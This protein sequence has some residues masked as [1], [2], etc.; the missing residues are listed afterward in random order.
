[1]ANTDKFLDL[2][3]GLPQLWNNAKNK[4]VSKEA[5]KGLVSID[6][7]LDATSK[8]SD[9]TVPSTKLMSDQLD[10]KANSADVA[11]TYVA[12]SSISQD[13]A[14]DTGSA[15]KVPSIAAVEGAITAAATPLSTNIATDSSSDAK[16]ATPKAVA[17]YAVAKTDISQD[18]TTDTGSTSKVL[19]VKAVE[20]A[21]AA[22]AT[23]ISQSITTDTGSTTKVPSVKAVED[24]IDSALSTVYEYKGSVAD[25][26]SLP[27]SGVATG[28]VYNIV[29]RSTYGEAGT[30]VAAIVDGSTITW[31]AL[32]GSFEIQAISAAEVDAVCV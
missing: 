5:G 6:T 23:P 13:I 8:A 21:I 17:D 10:L 12:K 31:D 30:N 19:S 4:F 1:M 7:V 15:V 16:A 22:A 3:V 18:A 24:A 9:A 32:G 14:S 28:D 27:T 20:D 11:D 29:A 26:A 25:A 2:A